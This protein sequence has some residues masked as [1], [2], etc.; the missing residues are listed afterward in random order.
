MV[1]AH[2]PEVSLPS[3]TM[4]PLPL[5]VERFERLP[6]PAHVRR[7]LDAAKDVR[8][9]SVIAFECRCAERD[10]DFVRAR[11]LLAGRA[12]CRPAVGA[13]DLVGQRCSRTLLLSPGDTTTH[14]RREASHDSVLI[15]WIDREAPLESEQLRIPAEDVPWM[16]DEMVVFATQSRLER[17]V[18]DVRLIVSACPDDS[19]PGPLILRMGPAGGRV[20]VEGRSRRIPR[21]P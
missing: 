2:V 7:V 15:S 3:R 17:R 18:L 12:S 13:S 20:V 14:S 8:H 9:G 16:R 5:P 1:I 4:V 11:V 21:R 6:F 19:G 10:G